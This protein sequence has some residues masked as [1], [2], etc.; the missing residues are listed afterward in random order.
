MM[1]KILKIYVKFF[2][3]PFLI[4]FK[5]KRVID[6]I[7]DIIKKIKPQEIE[8]DGIV[9]STDE[10]KI[11]GRGLALKSKEPDTI[12]WIDHYINN[13]EVLYDIGANI[14]VFSLYAAHNINNIKVYSFEPESS[15]Y[16]YLNKN[17]YRNKFDN[18]ILALNIALNDTS[19]ISTLNL[20]SFIAGGSMHNFHD[21]LDQNHEKLKPVFKQ[22]AVGISLDELVLNFGLP[23]PNHIKIDVDGNEY[24]VI[25]G[26]TKILRNKKL[27]S[28]A[29]ELNDNLEIDDNIVQIIIESGFINIDNNHFLVNKRYKDNGWPYNKYFIRV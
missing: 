23:V 21:E 12:Y 9:F 4:F 19:I 3:F 29:I 18:T 2:L 22:G 25:N 14:G 20:S 26:M 7:I 11:A 10:G 28:I 24:K 27:K 8:V 1:K 15:N 5:K 17:I 6:K 13:D 16:Y